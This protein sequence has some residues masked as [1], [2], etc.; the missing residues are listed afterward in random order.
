NTETSAASIA[1]VTVQD[2]AGN[3]STPQGPFG[4][5][6]VDKK[7]PTVT[8][9]VLSVASPSFGQSVMAAYTCADGGSGVVLC[10]PSQQAA[11]IAPVGSVTINTTVD[12]SVGQHTFTAYTQDLVGH[13]ASS[14]VTYTVAKAVPTI[15]WA[16]PAPITFGTP[17]S[18]LQLNASAN[19][20]GTFS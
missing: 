3:F 13:V 17:L 8:T 11:Q 18:T 15:T 2:V 7:S 5:F 4:P 16:T 20:P 1:A 19:V 9:P 10:A 12:T 14:S 6:Q